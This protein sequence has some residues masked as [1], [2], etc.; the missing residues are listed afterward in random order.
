MIASKTMLSPSIPGGQ[1]SQL[2]YYNEYAVQ[3]R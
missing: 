1:P 2:L 3:R